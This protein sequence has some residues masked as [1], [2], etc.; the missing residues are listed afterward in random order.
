MAI[1][2]QICE[3]LGLDMKGRDSRVSSLYHRSQ[4]YHEQGQDQ[5]DGAVQVGMVVLFQLIVWTVDELK[6]HLFLGRSP[7]MPQTQGF[8]YGPHGTL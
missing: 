4:K 1:I 8:R 7:D 3:G 5:D 6:G 2:T